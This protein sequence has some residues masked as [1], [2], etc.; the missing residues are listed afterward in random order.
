VA[1]IKLQQPGKSGK[2]KQGRE[3]TLAMPPFHGFEN[4]GLFNFTDN[5]TPAGL[6]NN[7]GTNKRS[8]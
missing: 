7:T 3:Q 8:G 2:S 4:F 6:G 5:N 1:K